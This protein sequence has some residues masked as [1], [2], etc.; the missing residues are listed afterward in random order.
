MAALVRKAGIECRLVGPDAADLGLA[1]D[2]LDAHALVLDAYS[3]DPAAVAAVAHRLAVVVDD[4]GRFPVAGDVVVNAALGL[5]APEGTAAR[6]LLGPSFALLAP[7]FA[8]KPARSWNA[9]VRRVLLTLGGATPARATASLAAAVR[10]AVPGAVLDVV[11]GPVGDSA[12]AVEAALGGVSGVVIHRAPADLRPLMLGAD[13]AVSGGGVTLLELAATAT[14]T[15]AVAVAAN[16]DGNLRGLERLDAIHHAGRIEEAAG[17]VGAAA[18]ALAGEP[19]R[20][21]ALGERAR[22]VVDGGGAA[23]VAAAVRAALAAQT[24]GGRAAC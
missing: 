11:V 6:Y 14:P 19:A 9:G 10:A 3:V 13:L 22:Q 21:R 1:L 18:A 4:S 24:V 7:A 12:D 2:G 15:V 20:R 17:A 5:R 23:R 8:E 16:Q